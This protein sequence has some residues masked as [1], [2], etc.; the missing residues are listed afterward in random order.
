M[1][2]SVCGANIPEG[3]TFC[4]VCGA[5]MVAFAGVPQDKIIVNQTEAQHMAA[6]DDTV[7]QL[8]PENYMQSAGDDTVTQL[9]P[10]NYMQ[11][12][13]DDTATV[14]LDPNLT[15]Q[16]TSN[17][18]PAFSQ[19]PGVGYQ[20]SYAQPQMGYQQSVVQPMYQP[21]YQ[22]NF[23]SSASYG[24]KKQ[25]PLFNGISLGTLVLILATV[26][27][28]LVFMIKPVYYTIESFIGGA[29]D[30]ELIE[31]A[32]EMQGGEDEVN[33]VN[34]AYRI[35][36]VIA[37]V[38]LV[39]AT[40]NALVCFLKVNAGCIKSP[41]LQAVGA[42]ILT[43]IGAAVIIALHVMFKDAIGDGLDYGNFSPE[44]VKKFNVYDLMYVLGI[45]S[46]VVSFVNIIT[47]AMARKRA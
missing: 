8:I 13:G 2:C 12:Q 25:S 6:G 42:F 47:S 9:I 26:I 27:S 44:E 1:N 45:V 20:Q 16:Y 29:A 39:I 38:F 37:V 32:M 40:I 46:I 4:S 41:T 5:D 19:G 21:N 18:Q 17:Q 22:Q 35:F 15:P 11:A 24:R 31:E 7:T 23:N 3:S 43:L 30:E 28:C 36:I 10:E 14:M 33:E 34:N